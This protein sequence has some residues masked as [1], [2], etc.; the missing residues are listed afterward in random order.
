SAF[1]FVYSSVFHGKRE[2]LEIY[3]H[4]RSVAFD[5]I[6]HFYQAF[7]QLAAQHY[8]F[9]QSH[10]HSLSAKTYLAEFDFY[11]ENDRI[12]RYLRDEILS[13][14][15]YE[16]LMSLLMQQHE[17]APEKA[18]RQLWMHN[19]HLL[20]LQQ[21]GHL[22]GLHSYS[23]PTRLGRLPY[24]K[25]YQ[26]YKDNFDHLHHLLGVPPRTMAHPCNSYNEET[27]HILQ[28]MGIQLGFRSNRTALA[29]RSFLE[30]PREDHIHLLPPAADPSRT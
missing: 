16:Q 10:L 8:P 25:Q 30:W 6:D 11:S 29:Q 17:Y 13:A 5:S 3:R 14:E 26:E 15:H 21:Q 4:F 22:I 20:S 19:D 1:W 18:A 7:F 24:N 23:H 28:E 2:Q 12:F 27:L 9:C